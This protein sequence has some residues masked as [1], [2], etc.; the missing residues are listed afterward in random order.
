MEP[1]VLG[2]LLAA[3][4]AL[5]SA[6]G[7]GNTTS[8]MPKL[9]T[10]QAASVVLGQPNFTT[11]TP[12]SALN[13]TGIRPAN[14]PLQ[15]GGY[16][17]VS[18]N[19][20]VS[21]TL[22]VLGFSVP[23]S[24]NQS[25][26]FALGVANLTAASTAIVD[27]ANFGGRGLGSDGTKFYVSDSL[28]NRILVFNALPSSNGASADKVLGQ[29]LL[30]TNNTPGCTQAGA[31]NPLGLINAGGKLIVADSGNNRVLIWTFPITGNGQNADLVLG[32]ANFTSCSANQGGTAAQATLDTPSSV[33]SDGTRLI[34]ADSQ[35]RRF[36][37][38]KTFPTTNG[39]LPDLV[40]G[41]PDFV[42][43][44]AAATAAEVASISSI[45]SNGTQLFVVDPLNNRVLVWNTF[46][47][48]NGQAA[49]MVLGQ[50]SLTGSAPGLTA[51]TL[52][53]PQAVYVFGA[54]IFVTDYGNSRLLM[55]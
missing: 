53:F 15:I 13:A 35:N 47:T 24:I 49:D 9:T 38:W 27:G 54:N 48:S 17:Y 14:R 51:T 36:L 25:A 39:Q 2:V 45:S 4:P 33:W 52:N 46:P 41:Q 22:R 21:G 23:I 28:N 1:R 7:G 26:A 16:L 32:Q 19:S 44:T 43:T 18:D 3:V 55:Y 42:T 37:I 29:S 50:T 31:S 30:A 12:P 10:G 6:C 11:N 20:G 40:G 8:A 34:V 5:I